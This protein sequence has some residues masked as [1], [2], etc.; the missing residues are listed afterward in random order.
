[1]ARAKKKAAKKQ[2]TAKK[3]SLRK[4]RD[5]SYEIVWDKARNGCTFGHHTKGISG[6]VGCGVTDAVSVF[7]DGKSCYV[8]SVN[9]DKGYA[10]LEV[11][12]TGDG[13][14]AVC[15]ADPADVQKL[16]P[17]D[18]TSHAPKAIAERL[19]KECM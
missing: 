10:C 18:L 4:L 15:F 5:T 3:G 16:F 12:D 19:A 6:E 13:P 7:T 11:L 1:M 9:Y 17:G 2:S 14:L 8:L